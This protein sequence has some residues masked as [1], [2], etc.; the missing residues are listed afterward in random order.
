ML[1]SKKLMKLLCC[2][3]VPAWCR[4]SAC[5]LPGDRTL[6]SAPLLPSTTKTLELWLPSSRAPSSVAEG[7]ALT[8]CGMVAGSLC[9]IWIHCSKL[10]LWLLVDFVRLCVLIHQ[11]R[12][13]QPSIETCSKRVMTTWAT[14]IG[15]CRTCA[16]DTFND[17]SHDK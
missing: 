10:A 2:M 9:M 12:R 8:R 17:D 6:S 16:N 11:C 13:Q 5:W 1:L 15:C 3:K 14:S 4:S 7:L